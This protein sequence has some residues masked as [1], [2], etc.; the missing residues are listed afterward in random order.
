MIL[1]RIVYILSRHPSGFY[2]GGLIGGAFDCFYF[3]SLAWICDV[4]PEGSRRSKRVGVFTGVVGGF[5]FIIGVPLG[6]A[7]AEFV[8]PSFPLKIGILLGG[9]C[10]VVL[11]I[12]PVDDTLGLKYADK[13]HIVYGKRMIPSD[14]KAYMK[15]HFPVSFGTIDMMKLANH[16]NDWLV[17]FIGHSNTSLLALI[18]VQYAL[19]VFHW[20]PVQAAGGY[21]A[22]GISIGVLGPV[23]LHRFQPV[24]LAFRGLIVFTVGLILF[25]VAGTGMAQASL[26]AIAGIVCIASGT[27]WVPALQTNLL[28]QYGPDVQGAVSG[29]LGQQKDAALVPAYIMSLGFTVSLGNDGPVYWP[30]ST[31]AVVSVTVMPGLTRVI[32]AIVIV[33]VLHRLHCWGWSAYGST[34][35]HTAHRQPL[36]LA[37]RLR[38]Y[39]W[40][41]Y[42]QWEMMQSW[43]GLGQ[44]ILQLMVNE[45]ARIAR[46][47]TLLLVLLIILYSK[48]I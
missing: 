34:T 13:G 30:G 18:F 19:A 3:T 7:L 1:S 48:Y 20:S 41:P 37:E 5:A 4:Y 14:Y 31:F 21:L 39:L 32:A 35:G 29:L 33:V 46:F 27:S 6:A 9:L 38:G 17:N 47:S 25:A 11:I 26:V 15:E 42:C 8:N 43:I 2:L 28:S 23:L 10:V 16:P 36:S 45:A 22:V 40:I 44:S 12:L 24:P